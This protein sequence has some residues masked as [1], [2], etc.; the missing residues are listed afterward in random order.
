[1]IKV[2]VSVVGAVVVVAAAVGGFSRFFRGPINPM[3]SPFRKLWTA[4]TWSLLWVVSSTYE[5][6][7]IK[8]V[9]WKMVVGACGEAAAAASVHLLQAGT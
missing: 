4:F 3:K 7:S 1:M 5:T 2:C 8:G 9:G 6:I